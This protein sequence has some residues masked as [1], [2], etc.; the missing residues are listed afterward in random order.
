MITRSTLILVIL[1]MICVAG[2]GNRQSNPSAATSAP[3]DGTV[4]FPP[5][6]DPYLT[7]A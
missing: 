7:A 6:L 4:Q 5:S 3:E 1:L 2:A